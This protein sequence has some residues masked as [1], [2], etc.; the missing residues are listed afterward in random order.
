MGFS[1]IS[2]YSLLDYQFYSIHRQPGA[3]GGANVLN[4]QVDG[5][6]WWNTFECESFVECA[7]RAK[8]GGR[9]HHWACGKLI[10]CF[11]VDEIGQVVFKRRNADRS[12]DLHTA[13]G[14]SAIDRKFVSGK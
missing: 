7:G 2:G 11:V 1:S 9:D 10:A 8:I 5:R 14:F 4:F 3:I 13:R 12:A 6:P